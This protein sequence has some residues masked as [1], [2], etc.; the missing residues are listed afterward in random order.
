MKSY[1]FPYTISSG[2]LDFVE[3]VFDY[4][5]SDED[6]IRLENYAKD[7]FRDSFHSVKEVEDIYDAVMEAI[8]EEQREYYRSD[9][10]EVIEYLAEEYDYEDEEDEDYEDDDDQD[11]SPEEFIADVTDDQIDEY[12]DCFDISIFFP[13]EV[14]CLEDQ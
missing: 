8:L 3:Y 6:A 1:A 14:T 12:L 10:S 7:N 4:D 5:L 11:E 9:P 2:K 13:K